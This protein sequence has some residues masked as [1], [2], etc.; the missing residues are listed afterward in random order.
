MVSSHLPSGHEEWQRSENQGWSIIMIILDYE[1]WRQNSNVTHLFFNTEIVITLQYSLQGE[2]ES[3]ERMAT[4][5]FLTEI[6][7]LYPNVLDGMINKRIIHLHLVLN[8]GRWKQYVPRNSTTKSKNSKR[9]KNIF[10]KNQ[11][12]NWETATT[13][14]PR[15]IGDWLRWS[16]FSLRWTGT[17]R[18]SLLEN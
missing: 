5:S 4:I 14:I 17:T 2:E 3:H 8:H 16:K 13:D 6:E 11:T 10:S 7:P 9:N 18:D 12:Q 1:G 15:R